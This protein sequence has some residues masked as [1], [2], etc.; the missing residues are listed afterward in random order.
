MTLSPDTRQK[1]NQLADFIEPLPWVELDDQ[2]EFIKPETPTRL[3]FHMTS[4]LKE[5][6]SGY[7]ACII[8]CGALLA[9]GWPDAEDEEKSFV[10]TPP[11]TRGT[12]QKW[13]NLPDDII[14]NLYYGHFTDSNLSH[15]YVDLDRIGPLDAAYA[16]RY[17]ATHGEIR[18][19]RN[20]I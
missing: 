9:N 17:L 20:L 18:W 1:L 16:L 14:E 5:F 10:L 4:I 12:F 7:V 2:M 6:S 19:P 13:T 8:G 15:Y 11:E 3:S